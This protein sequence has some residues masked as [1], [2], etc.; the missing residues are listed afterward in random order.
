PYT[1]ALPQGSGPLRLWTTDGDQQRTAQ[2]VTKK[3]PSDTQGFYVPSGTYSGDDL[4][5]LGFSD[6]VSS[7]T[8]YIERV[9]PGTS[10][11]ERQIKVSLSPDGSTTVASDP[12]LVG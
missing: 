11:A 9:R 8:L 1:Y 10:T 3:G 5:K 12:L 7:I 2:S 4:K 6:G